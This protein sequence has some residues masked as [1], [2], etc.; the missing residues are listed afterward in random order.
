M[1]RA[2]LNSQN[3]TL[4]CLVFHGHRIPWLFLYCIHVSQ[5]MNSISINV[6]QKS[7]FSVLT[8]CFYLYS[9]WWELPFAAD[10]L[11]SLEW[12]DHI[13]VALPVYLIQS[14]CCYR[15]I[16]EDTVDWRPHDKI[17]LS[18]SSYEP[19]EAE[20]L[21]VKE[22]RGHHIRIHERLRHRHIGK[23]LVCSLR[24][25]NEPRQT[26]SATCLGTL[27]PTGVQRGWIILC[28]CPRLILEGFI[29]IPSLILLP[30][31]F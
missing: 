27:D 7:F 14:L 13:W 6:L 26:C 30:N 1:E 12:V 9:P 3:F 19:H 29:S 21:T 20:V 17:V 22:V 18:S 8:W 16:V 28:H 25:V 5:K 4:S 10:F 23:S 2:L 11:F 31:F 24:E 15:I